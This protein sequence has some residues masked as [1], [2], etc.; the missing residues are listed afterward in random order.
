MALRKRFRVLSGVDY[1]PMFAEF[2]RF[3]NHEMAQPKGAP[4]NHL[5]A[6][7]PMDFESEH[8]HSAT[9]GHSM[10]K[11]EGGILVPNN[12]ILTSVPG[13][14]S[15][16]PFAAPAY[17]ISA[18]K[19]DYFFRPTSAIVSD[20]PNRNG[21]GFPAKE[22][23]RWN[24]RS[25]C[26]AYRS[27]IGK[28]VHVEHGNW[29]PDPQDPDPTLAIGVI[30]DVA[31]TPL[32]GYGENKLWKIMMLVAIDRTKDIARAKE[33]EAGDLNTYSMG[34]LVDGYTCSYC[35]SDVGDCSHIDKDD[36]LTFY[37]LKNVLV[38]KLCRGIEGVEISSV[39][40]PAYA[41]AISD[42]THI[43]Y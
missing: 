3:G 6:H 29:H 23:V 2:D 40:D 1:Q 7:T 11:T 20:L 42:V 34:A 39:R 30:V 37:K 17:N 41:A 35:G 12:E 22:L 16:L 38:Y 31:M 5:Q 8:V 26:Q 21:V 32:I 33:I 18:D 43:K 13:F 10:T 36:D 19:N 4:G 27:W 15:W 9:C 14:E 28:P 25:G 24:V